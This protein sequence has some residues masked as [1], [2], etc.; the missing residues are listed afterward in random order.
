MALLNYGGFERNTVNND[1]IGP[2]V[3]TGSAAISAAKARTGTYSMK[4]PSHP[5]VEDYSHA[6]FPLAAVTAE[7]FY[8]FSI[9]SIRS[10]FWS[11]TGSYSFFAWLS[12]STVIGGLKWNHVTQQI[13]IYLGNFVS[14]VASV[15]P[16]PLTSEV[17]YDFEIHIKIHATGT[18]ALRLDGAT[19]HTY[20]GDTTVVTFTDISAVEWRNHQGAAAVVDYYLD[21]YC[22]V[23]SSGIAPLNTWPGPMRVS[24]MLPVSDAGTND[25]TPEPSGDHYATVDELPPSA[26]DYLEA[27]AADVVEKFGLSA[28]PGTAQQ[29][30]AITARAWGAYGGAGAPQSLAVGVD[31]A[32]TEGY[33]GD[34][35][36]PASLGLPVDYQMTARPG[37]GGLSVSVVNAMKL[38]IKS[39]P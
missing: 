2:V 1:S 20:S 35:L 16:P 11:T 24:E 33:S 25:M 18:I 23:S 5:T 30:F 32:A 14:K 6:R 12:G 39:R 36:L 19:F 37:G 38:A 13:D 3:I 31:D 15:T 8:K 34:L 21:D 4:I 28:L 26:T 10:G 22:F 17:W 9:L 29:V 7:G 27:S